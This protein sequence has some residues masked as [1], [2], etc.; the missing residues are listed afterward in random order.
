MEATIIRV[1]VNM[2][3]K[4]QL[5]PMNSMNQPFISWFKKILF[6]FKYCVSKD[7]NIKDIDWWVDVAPKNWNLFQTYLN[8]QSFTYFPIK[9]KL[10]AGKGPSKIRLDK[11]YI[12]FLR[13]KITK[14]WPSSA[15]KRENVTFFFS[16]IYLVVVIHSLRGRKS[17]TSHVRHGL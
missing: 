12:L 3:N 6:N 14:F 16:K 4:F 5:W 1:R 2:M 10:Q 17:M 13:L 9:E 7:D 11:F 8:L 15:H